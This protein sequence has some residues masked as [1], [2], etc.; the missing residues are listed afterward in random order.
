M[1]PLSIAF[2]VAGIAAIVVGAFQARGPRATDRH[3]DETEAN[4]TRYEAWRGKNTGVGAD[5]PTGADIMCQQ[6]RQRPSLGAALQLRRGRGLG[7]G[8]RISA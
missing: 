7:R 2:V 3:L 4:L 1:N 6:M 8:R 5:G